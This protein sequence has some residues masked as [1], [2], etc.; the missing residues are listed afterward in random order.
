MSD[1]PKGIFE[2]SMASLNVLG[3]RVPDGFFVNDLTGPG[4][5][6]GIVNESTSYATYHVTLVVHVCAA[7]HL[8]DWVCLDC[9]G[10]LSK[11]VGPRWENFYWRGNQ[12]YKP[13]QMSTVYI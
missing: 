12:T 4:G 6:F 8:A 2:L 3:A 5:M 1:S 10:G 13:L 7:A 9:L 11:R